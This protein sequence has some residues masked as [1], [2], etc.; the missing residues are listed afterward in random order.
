MEISEPNRVVIVEVR[1]F[2]DDGILP[3]ARIAAVDDASNGGP[4]LMVCRSDRRFLAEWR[5]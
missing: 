3:Q 1:A 2:N 5:Q 4:P